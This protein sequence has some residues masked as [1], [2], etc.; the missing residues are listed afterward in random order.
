M[1][2]TA[3]QIA[4]TRAIVSW[5]FK[6]HHGS[7]HDV[8]LP[9]MFMSSRVVGEFAV[10]PEEFESGDPRALFRMLIAC[11]MFQR[12]R[13]QLVLKILQ[14]MPTRYA[15]EIADAAKL[16]TW[17][18]ESPCAHVKST[19][20]LREHCDLTKDKSGHGCCSYD[21][22]CHLKEHTVAMK[23]YGHFGKVPTSISLAIAESGVD[24]LAELYASVRAIDESERARS[25]RLEATLSRAWRVNQKI[26]S[27]FLS[28]VTNPDLARPAVA[29]WSV[30]I[31]WAYFVVIDSN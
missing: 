30:D 5:Y 19:T 9:A 23:R 27:M 6:T 17:A 29:P 24:N 16:R 3:T 2:I 25:V 10:T 8:G 21:I 4:A 18:R 7:Q 26:A 22:Q 31:D 12:L 20:S 13:D 1:K 14:N 28:L 15:R 11:S